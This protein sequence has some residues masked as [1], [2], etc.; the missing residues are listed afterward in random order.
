MC[1]N[2]TQPAGFLHCLYLPGFSFIF[3]SFS[4]LRWF[5]R[6]SSTRTSA[7]S[8][9]C[10]YG[11][12]VLYKS[13]HTI[14]EKHL[15]NHCF[16]LGSFSYSLYLE[17]RLI[18]PSS[19]C[20]Q[21]NGIGSQCLPIK[22]CCFKQGRFSWPVGILP[23]VRTPFLLRKKKAATQCRTD[24]TNALHIVLWVGGVLM[25]GTG[26]SE[27]AFCVAVVVSGLHQDVGWVSEQSLLGLV[28]DSCP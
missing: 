6:A 1:V 26:L 17:H 5:I 19:T 14:S 22:M 7:K 18:L 3:A 25:L 8:C 9:A 21:K 13:D 2:I 4:R 15:P 20:W 24:I 28:S 23:G 12:G 11:L 27:K 16:F 10:R